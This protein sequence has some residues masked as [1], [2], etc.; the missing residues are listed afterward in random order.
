MRKFLFIVFALVLAAPFVALP[1]NMAA[2]TASPAQIAP[3]TPAAL[4]ADE[5]AIIDEILRELDAARKMTTNKDIQNQLGVIRDWTRKVMTLIEQGNDKGALEIKYLIARRLEELIN[6]LP[7]LTPGAAT[8]ATAAPSVNP[9]YEE[10]VRIRAKIEK[11]IAIEEREVP[12]MVTPRPPEITRPPEMEKLIVYSAKFLCGPAFGGEGVQ[13]G[14]YSTAI[15]IHN[16]HNY[17][18]YLYKKAVI[19][20]REDEPRGRI[21]GFRKVVLA[22]DEAIEVDCI[23]ISSFFGPQEVSAYQAPSQQATPVGA[24]S[25]TPSIATSVTPVNQVVRFIKGFVVLYTTAPLDVVG[26]YTASTPNGFSLDVEHIPQSTVGVLP[27]PVPE[28]PTGQACPAGCYCMTKD[29]AVAK[30]GPDATLCQRE[31]C[32]KDASGNPMYCWK[33]SEIAK[34]P[35]GCLCMTVEA[36][37]QRGYTD[38]CMAD[39]CG[40]DQYQNLMYCFK[41][42]SGEACPTGCVCLTKDEA[43]KRYG[44]KLTLCQEKPCGREGNIEKYCWKVPTTESCPT[45]CTC[46]AKEEGYKLGYEVCQEQPCGYDE[47]LSMAKLCFRRPTTQACPSDCKCLTK[48]EAARSGLTTLCQ[49]QPCGYIEGP[50]TGMRTP[51]YCWKPTLQSCPAGCAC[52]TDAEAKRLGYTSLCQ[53]QRVLCGYDAQQ[54]PQYCFTKPPEVTQ[55]KV[56]RIVIDPVSDRNPVGTRHNLTISVYDTNGNSMANVRVKISHTGAHTFAPIELVTDVNG[57]A[58]YY[59]DG[60]NVG[61]DTIVATADGVSTKATKEWYQVVKPAKIDLSPST[62]RNAPGQR[63]TVVATVWGSDGNPMAGVTVNFS[64]T[65]TNNLSGS[66]TTDSNGKASFSYASK[67]EGKDTITATVDNLRATATKYWEVLR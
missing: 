55:P 32:D 25:A 6:Q 65:G 34:C 57:K 33:P 39:P 29:D 44:D 28:E 22:P 40:R 2:E 37:K 24:S 64:V 8:T 1:V 23:D 59:Y 20:Q 67:L 36:A 11:L 53:G 50:Q 30:F 62:G 42:P 60:K 54:N 13:P 58:G 41:V 51:Q 31:P 47:K 16:P 7:T 56:G 14:S 61:T 66:A 5:K 27:I 18:V 48:E 4:T 46:L 10:L 35:E 63:H 9:L 19:A 17:T 26:V 21:S 49:E 45:G 38:R 15:N 43:Y 12:T 3:A 52:L